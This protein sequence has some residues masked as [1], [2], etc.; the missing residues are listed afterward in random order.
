MTAAPPLDSDPITR[1]IGVDDAEP[2]DVDDL[3]YKV[4]FVDTSF[5]VALRSGRDQ[6]HGG[7]AVARA[8]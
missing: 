6:R 3:V 1:M 7:G 4:I 2:A 8:C 5:W